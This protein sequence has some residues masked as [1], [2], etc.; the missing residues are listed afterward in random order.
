MGA[1]ENANKYLQLQHW[2]I[3]HLRDGTAV[4][5]RIIFDALV[6]AACSF[7]DN[8]GP[9]RVFRSR[10]VNMGQCDSASWP[11]LLP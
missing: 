3:R 6:L 10:C 7:G 1:A 9:E 11:L 5:R 4:S 8:C 2:A